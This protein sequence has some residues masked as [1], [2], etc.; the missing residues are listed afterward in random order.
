MLI[1]IDCGHGCPPDTG[2]SGCGKQEDTLAKNLGFKVAE[3]LVS[4]GHQVKMVRPSA[5]K[6]VNNSLSLRAS[7]ANAAKA[8]LYVSIHFNAFS[9]PAANGA[10][11]WIY[12][13]NSKI[14]DKANAVLENIC[15]LGYTRRGVKI[16]SFAVLRLTNMPAMLVECCFLTNQSDIN[17]YDEDKVALAISK[18]ILEKEPINLAKEKIVTENIELV[19]EVDTYLKIDTTEQTVNVNKNQ[20]VFIKKGSYDALLVGEEE[21]HYLVKCL[22]GFS[23]EQEY[24]IYS[25]HCKILT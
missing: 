12:S 4:Q 25:G 11:V 22:D 5:A 9:N 2:A 23:K 7:Y 14:K 24:F 6:S 10:E 20:L 15:A 16:G 1:A 3:I 19:V 17:K 21:G 13:S 18:G 8:D